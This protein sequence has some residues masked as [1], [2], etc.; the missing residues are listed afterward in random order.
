MNT[1]NIFNILALAVLMPAILFS[2]ACSKDDNAINTDKKGYELPV[3]INACRQGDDPA[4]RSSYNGTSK[5][6]E[7]STGDKLLVTGT[8]TDAGH[9]AGMLTWTSGGTFSGTIITENEYSGTAQELLNA[10]A[11]TDATLLPNGYESYGF[12]TITGEGTCSAYASAEY[13]NAFATSKAT[14]VEQFSYESSYSYSS[15]FALTPESAILNFTITDLAK[16][17]EV[18]VAFSGECSASGTVTTDGSGTATFA[19]GV[20]GD[21]TDLNG[22]SLTVGGNAITLVNSSKTLEAGK[23][24]N[25][26]RSTYP[27][28][29]AATTADYG[30]VVCAAG[31][32]HDAKTAVP[33]GCTAVGILGKVTETGHGLILALQNAISQ[34]WDTIFGWAS[35]TTYAGTTLK[36]LPDNAARGVKLTSYTALGATAVSNWAV[37]QK[38]D[39][40]AIFTNLGST[41]SIWN[42]QPYDDNVNAYITGAGGAALSGYYWSASWK[43]DYKAWSFYSVYWNPDSNGQ[44]NKVRPVLGF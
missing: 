25:I 27:L 9:F 23:I 1:K 15:G 33:A 39:Y 14:A 29:S 11:Q 20:M 22:I 42:G 7:F 44:L 12:L 13:D 3:T 16:S 32:L 35:V 30:K 21:Y 37:A 24:Y 36:V 38:S 31:H 4:T 10:A 2:T 17:T 18:A 19:V 41:A 8:D 6:L 43:D 34:T 40:E 5:K 28:L 26:T